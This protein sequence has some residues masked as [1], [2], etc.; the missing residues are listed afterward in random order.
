[1]RARSAGPSA[2]LPPR[3]FPVILRAAA[4]FARSVQKSAMG[5]EFETNTEGGALPLR[6]VAPSPSWLRTV[7][8][9]ARDPHP[10][11]ELGGRR[12]FSMDLYHF[13]IILRQGGARLM[14]RAK[15]FSHV[16]LRRAD[17]PDLG[18]GP[19]RG[20]RRGDSGPKPC[21]FGRGFGFE[22]GLEEREP[23]TP[24]HAPMRLSPFG[25][26]PRECHGER[27][28]D[29]RKRG[30]Q[31]GPGLS[32]P[33]RT[34]GRKEDGSDALSR[35]ERRIWPLAAVLRTGETRTYRQFWSVP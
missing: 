28:S 35:S 4:R 16:H 27:L 19:G 32:A 2:F 20:P 23:T 34:I 13:C 29:G 21:A 24:N 9:R 11:S 31:D 5:K 18:G 12:R 1:M 33:Y 26:A 6:G 30:P 8:S 10:N 14:D 7:F 3:R 17:D 22:F 25:R 15:P